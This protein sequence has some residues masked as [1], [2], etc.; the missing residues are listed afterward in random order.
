MD[1]FG[2]KPVRWL[3][4][5]AFGVAFHLAWMAINLDFSR[6]RHD[7]GLVLSKTQETHMYAKLHH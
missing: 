5:D 2:L 6:S 1:W 7:V 3:W 4:E